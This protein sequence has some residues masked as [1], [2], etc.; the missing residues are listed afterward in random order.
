[1][2]LIRSALAFS[3][4]CATSMAGVHSGKAEASWFAGS[5]TWQAGQPVVTVVRLAVDPHWHTYWENPGEGGMKI[6][7]KWELPDGWTAG[8]LGHPLP[9]RFLTGGLPGFGYEGTVL[10]PVKLT[11]PAGFKGEARLKAK[12]SWLTCND[13]SCVP[14]DATLEITLPEGAPSPTPQAAEVTEALKKIPVP[15]D[16]DATLTVARKAD[17]LV[18]TVVAR[19]G[20]DFDPS[21][22]EAFPATPQAVDAASPIEFKKTGDH[23]SAEVRTSEYAPEAIPQLTLVFG[24]KSGN[25]RSLTW[26]AP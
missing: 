15:A 16:D 22:G 6:S 14:G 19:V 8:P 7:A 24:G 21:G 25:P 26:K 13:S 1:M 4:L 12:F 11:P 17:S 5:S 9:K 18:L 20:K 10:F 23:W 3:S 2:I